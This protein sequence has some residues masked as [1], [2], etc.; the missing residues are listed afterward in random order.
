MVPS[1]SNITA[2]ILVFGLQDS[3]Q[4]IFKLKKCVCVYVCE[5]ERERERERDKMCVGSEMRKLHI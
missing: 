4:L 1:K 2:K 5:R 3:Q